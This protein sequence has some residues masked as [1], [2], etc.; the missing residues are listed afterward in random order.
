MVVFGLISSAFDLLTFALLLKAFDATQPVF[1]TAWFIVSVLTE[2][3]VVLVLRTHLS[4]LHSRPG[5]LLAWAT[6]GVVLASLLLPYLAPLA[7]LFAFVALPWPVLAA[8]LG[9][10]GAYVL[11][12]EYAK[13]WFWRA[14]RQA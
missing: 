14:S 3:A 13:R 5:R 2:L 4:A 6:A 12:T 1:Q 10:V 7:G 11:V 8:M 9:V